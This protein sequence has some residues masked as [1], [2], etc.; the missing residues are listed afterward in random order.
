[1]GVPIP[2]VLRRQGGIA[3]EQKVLQVFLRRGLGEV[4]TAGDDQVE[5]R[6]YAVAGVPS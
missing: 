6:L 5:C 2:L 1:M 4:E 3:Q